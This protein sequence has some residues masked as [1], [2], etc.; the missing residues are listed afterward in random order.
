MKEKELRENSIC[1]FCGEKIGNGGL[2]FWRIRLERFGVDIRAVSR[3]QGL[4][5]MLGGHAQLAMAMGLDEE[6]AIPVMAPL[7][8]VVCDPCG[9]KEKSIERLAETRPTGRKDD[10]RH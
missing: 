8:L 1:S 9:E 2:F 6:M 4:T 10:H 5:M 3:Q 7:T